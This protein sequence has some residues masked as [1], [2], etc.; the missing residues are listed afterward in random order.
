[1]SPSYPVA[2]PS[3]SDLK[4]WQSASLTSLLRELKAC[5]QYGCPSGTAQLIASEQP[6]EVN[7]LSAM[8]RK[9]RISC[10]AKRLTSKPSEICFRR[11]LCKPC[12]R[13]KVRKS[14]RS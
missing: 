7:H 12:L 6:L 14:L 9:E 8:E 4:R 5:R 3:K 10:S 2:T 1:M 13:I 11:R